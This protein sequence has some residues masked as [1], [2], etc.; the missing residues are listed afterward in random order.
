MLAV[1][2]LFG[3]AAHTS[4]NGVEARLANKIDNSR[5]IDAQNVETFVSQE[6]D[7]WQGRMMVAILGVCATAYP[8]GKL[9]WIVGERAK[10]VAATKI[11]R[12][13]GNGS[14]HA[15]GTA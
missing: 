9:I 15:A 2:V 5:K 7:K 1:A 12:R 11:T 3:C 6:A 14:V 4:L 10:A 8:A 13:N